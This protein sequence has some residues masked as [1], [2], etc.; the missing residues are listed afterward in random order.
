MASECKYDVVASVGEYTDRSTGNKKKNYVKCGVG[1][2][3][4]KGQISLKMD[5]VP[6]SPEW[7]GWFSLYERDERQS[8]EPVDRK[9]QAG[10]DEIPDPP[11]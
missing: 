4:D 1:F 5:T 3:N 6:V 10:D 11:F 7:S 9:P 2:V 8:R